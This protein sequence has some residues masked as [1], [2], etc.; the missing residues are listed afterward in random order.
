[1]SISDYSARPVPPWLRDAERTRAIPA[2]VWITGVLVLIAAAIRIIV[3]NN[4]SFWQDE[5]LTAYEASLPLGAMINTVVHVETTPPLYFLV[6]WV[7]AHVFGT[8]DVALRTLSMLAGVALVPIAYLSG[9]D[10]VNARAGVVAAALVTFNPFLIW[11]SQEAR[12]Y[13]LL[14]ALS[15]LSFLWFVRARRQPTR[16]NLA[17]W[18]V[19]SSLA[20]MTHFFAG[21]LVAPEALWLLWVARTRVTAVAVAAV[22][23]VQVAMLP[24]ALTD[25][26]HG[27]GWIA[28]TPRRVRLA[29]A[30][31]EWGVSILYRRT[32]VTRSLLAGVVLLVL[33]TVLLALRGDRRVRR[34][35][36]VAAVIG[37]FVWAAPLALGV[38]SHSHDYFLSRNVIPAVVP[39][40]VLI[41][42]ACVVPRLR[43]LGALLAV[44]LVAMFSYA[45]IQVQTHAYLQRPDWRSVARALGPA[46][47][48]RAIIAANGVTADPLKIYLPR[49][50]WVQ[51]QSQ[52]VLVDEVDVVGD[53]KQLPLRPVRFAFR[54]LPPVWYT[55]HGAPTPALIGPPGAKLVDRFIVRN[56]IIG[57]FVLDHPRRM[58]VRQLIA[59]APGYFHR[60]PNAML[61]FFQRAER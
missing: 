19:W 11:Y 9:R 34:G 50:N 21:F 61:I 2:E 48:P 59:L 28:E 18:A 54:N 1:M 32:T 56:W 41:A 13:M 17:W 10:L 15:G 57:R 52:R 38:L 26:G 29:Q 7:W 60:T 27:V 6:V 4:Q 8:S 14:A 3:L 36:A 20:L 39:V 25:T 12:A 46:L 16:R 51:A 55:P 35:A 24:F 30:V 42:A 44:V 5:A 23:A 49:V 43:V 53:R 40:A 22:A 31:A 37:G 33:I 45:T 47:V 58:S